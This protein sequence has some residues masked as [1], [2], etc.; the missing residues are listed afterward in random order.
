MK[1]E[2]K[3]SQLRIIPTVT[4]G[5]TRLILVPQTPYKCPTAQESWTNE[6]PIEFGGIKLTD[7]AN[8]DY[9]GLHGRDDKVLDYEG[10]RGTIL[11][12]LIVR[13][14]SSAP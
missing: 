14:T 2:C 4:F 13:S 11:C 3:S 6:G 9:L 10:V 5:P 7:A 12:R 8:L 1:T